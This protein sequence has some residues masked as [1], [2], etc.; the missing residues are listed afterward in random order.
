M[1]YRQFYGL[2]EKPFTMI[3]KPGCLYPSAGHSTALIYL[4]Y[5][6]RENI[7]FIL[8]TGEIGTGKTTLI[9]SLL[10]RI[11][12][13]MEVAVL[14]NT[15]VS[16]EELIRGILREYE[17]DPVADKS[18]N[19]DLL[20]SFLIGQYAKRRRVLLIVD[21]AQNLKRE[22]LEELRM[23]SNLVGESESLIQI[24]L[25]G[26]PEL[27]RT[28][29]HPSLEQLA[30]RIG[31]SYHL[32]PMEQGDTEEYIRY[33]LERAGCEKADLFSAEAIDSIHQAC[34]G[35][36]RAINLLCD[37]CLVYGFAD[38]AQSI[39]PDIVDQVLQ[40]R[41]AQELYSEQSS[42]LG[43]EPLHSSLPE[44]DDPMLWGRV[45]HV[46]ERL[47][48]LEREV[49]LRLDQD[50]DALVR[51]LGDQLQEERK[52]CDRLQHLYGR[53]KAQIALLEARNAAFR[54]AEDEIRE[55]PAI[56]SEKPKPELQHFAESPMPMERT[57]GFGMGRSM[58]LALAALGIALGTVHLFV[59]PL[60]AILAGFFG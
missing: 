38:D 43:A 40:D 8:L 34:K 6:L 3:P 58:L 2:R 45:Q 1:M 48:F 7:G 20:N 60:D 4:E 28:I 15:N 32:G 21:E 25:V 50:R 52:K 51:S 59:S 18:Q 33:R 57:A 56:P 24:V 41:Q 13:E 12:S 27:R 29:R 47:D 10:E 22:A 19:L 9:R 37:A 17:L 49:R 14:F 16:E 23:L 31:V 46:M 53:A 11:E 55:Q 5:G 44:K 35:I 26:Q 36:P 30:Q 39:T 54:Q 42:E